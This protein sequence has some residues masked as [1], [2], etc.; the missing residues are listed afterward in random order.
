MRSTHTYVMLEIS[1]PAFKEIEE[2][3]RLAQY[4][5][6]FHLEAGA[7][8]I[9]MHGLALVAEKPTDGTQA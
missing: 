4:D 9:D 8:L 5:H 2:K 6:C 7:L 3:L 1:E